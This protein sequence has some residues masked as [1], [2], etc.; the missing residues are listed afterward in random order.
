MG[1]ASKIVGAAAHAISFESNNYSFDTIYIGLGSK[2]IIF[3]FLS[4]DL[5]LELRTLM[6]MRSPYAINKSSK[7]EIG[8]ATTAL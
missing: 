5:T 7:P 4:I 8:A 2:W 6:G 3:D 1:D